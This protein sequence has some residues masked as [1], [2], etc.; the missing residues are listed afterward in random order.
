M[1]NK[2]L[3]EYIHSVNLPK[4]IVLDWLSLVQNNSGKVSDLGDS[5]AKN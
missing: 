5:L 4:K 2:K 3:L 1:H